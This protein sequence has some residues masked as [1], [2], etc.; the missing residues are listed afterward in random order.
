MTTT[1]AFTRTVGTVGVD[2]PWRRT[3]PYAAVTITAIAPRTLPCGSRRGSGSWPT[4]GIAT[5]AQRWMGRLRLTIRSQNLEEE[6]AN[7]LRQPA[8]QATVVLGFG[9][10]AVRKVC[11]HSVGE[12]CP[13][14]VPEFS[15]NVPVEVRRPGSLQPGHDRG[16]RWDAHHTGH[17][18]IHGSMPRTAQA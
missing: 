5:F 7:R 18:R 14:A 4:G 16:V 11:A 9:R 15:P 10:P 13:I 3:Y 1:T 8:Q 6:G 17:L 12:P 2:P